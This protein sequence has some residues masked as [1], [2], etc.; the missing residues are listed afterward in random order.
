MVVCGENSLIQASSDENEPGNTATCRKDAWND[1]VPS[2][3]H[4]VILQPCGDAVLSRFPIRSIR[5]G[6]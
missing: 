4:L 3:E 1:P 5:E 6:V 2:K